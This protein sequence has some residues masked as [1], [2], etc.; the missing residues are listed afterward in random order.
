MGPNILL[1]FVKYPTPGKVKTRLAKT[2]GDDGAARLYRELAEDNFQAVVSLHQRGVCAA[3]VVFDPPEKERDVQAWLPASGEYRPQR[4]EGLGERL[5][6][7][8]YDAFQK[9]ARRVIAVGS[10]TLGLTAE[11]MEK[12]FDCLEEADVVV[13]PAKDGGY[14]LIGLSRFR[15]ALFQDVAWS[16]DRVLSQTY[17]IISALGL[18]HQTL[19]RLEDLDEIK[20]GVVFSCMTPDGLFKENG[21]Q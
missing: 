16:T 13:G 9:G 4:G 5:S 7:A 10:D 21:E 6:S 20:A 12:G 11:I 1:Y 8:F 15:P 18:S 2:L 3:V 14:Y 19:V 17:D